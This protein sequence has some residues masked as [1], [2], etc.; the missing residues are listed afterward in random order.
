MEEKKAVASLN[1]KPEPC[2]RCRPKTPIEAGDEIETDPGPAVALAELKESPY[3]LVNPTPK[4]RICGGEAPTPHFCGQSWELPVC[5]HKL[6]REVAKDA[7]VA[8]LRDAPGEHQAAERLAR[9]HAYLEAAHYIIRRLREEGF[10]LLA[11]YD[12]APDDLP[13]DN[14]GPADEPRVV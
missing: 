5:G 10:N 9:T 12:A 1:G 7:E 6:C 8:G 13:T 4:C 11:I 3:L 2:E 14:P